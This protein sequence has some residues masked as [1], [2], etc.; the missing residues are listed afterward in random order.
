MAEAFTGNEA[1]N[2]FEKVNPV[3][4]ILDLMLPALSG[5]E[6]CQRLRK[7]SPVPIIMLTA[8]VEE[9]DILKGLD[10]GTDDFVMKP[11]NPR[12]LVA[13]V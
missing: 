1:L 11:F 7:R 5:E 6:V 3:L 8:K 10:L 13:R 2:L 9:E 4:V 12:Q